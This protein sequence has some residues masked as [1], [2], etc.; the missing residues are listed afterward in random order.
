MPSIY[1]LVTF[2][3]WPVLFVI[4]MFGYIGLKKNVRRPQIRTYLGTTFLIILG[5]TFLFNSN[6][7]PDFLGSSLTPATVAF[8]LFGDVLCIAGIL[9]AIWARLT[10]GTNWSGAIATVKENHELMQKGPYQIVRHPIYTGFFFAMLGTALT[11]GNVAAYLGVLLGLIAFLIR[12]PLEERV[13]TE[14]FPNAY[15]NYK[16]KT[17]GLIPWVW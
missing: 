14:Q 2:W 16:Q 8:G 5:F 15:P 3:S 13:M 7:A 12:I 9:F 1:T 6:M 4:W 11:I 10:L 17:K